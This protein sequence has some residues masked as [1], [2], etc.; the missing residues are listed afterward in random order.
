MGLKP[1]SATMKLLVIFMARGQ[2]TLNTGCIV[3][4]IVIFTNDYE[5]SV[6]ER[7]GLS[8]QQVALCREGNL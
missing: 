1:S 6:F 8:N 5:R 7:R 2:T 3:I 4:T